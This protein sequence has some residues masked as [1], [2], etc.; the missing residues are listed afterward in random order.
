MPEFELHTFKAVQTIAG[1]KDSRFNDWFEALD[2]MKNEIMKIDFDNSIIG[3]WCLWY[4]IGG[5]YKTVWKAGDL[6]W[7]CSSNDFWD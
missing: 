6:C 4:A 2:Y 1:V 5:T 7:R 3:M